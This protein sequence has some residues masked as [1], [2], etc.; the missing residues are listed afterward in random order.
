VDLTMHIARNG[1]GGSG[2]SVGKLARRVASMRA[3]MRTAASGSTLHDESNN[4]RQ[5][6]E[7]NSLRNDLPSAGARKLMM[8]SGL[9]NKKSSLTIVLAPA[10]LRNRGG[11]EVWLFESP[12]CT[13]RKRA[14]VYA[15]AQQRSPAGCFRPVYR[16]LLLSPAL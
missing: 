12:F 16:P 13:C 4:A 5:P 15:R 2:V 3:E 1:L 6:I 7:P 8:K 11:N 10:Q 9:L 14:G